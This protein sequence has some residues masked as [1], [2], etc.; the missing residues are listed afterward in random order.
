MNTLMRNMVLMCFSAFVLNTAILAHAD[1]GYSTDYLQDGRNRFSIEEVS[2]S[3]PSDSTLWD[4]SNIEHLG[5]SRKIRISAMSDSTFAV[6][7]NDKQFTFKIFNDSFTNTYDALDRN[8]MTTL[9]INESAAQL[10]QTNTYDSLGRLQNAAMGNNAASVSYG[11]NLRG[12]ATGITSN[13][14][15]QQI[16]YQDT[17]GGSTPCFNG[18][19][20]SMAWMQSGATGNSLKSGRYN[21]TYDMLDRL[22]AAAFADNDNRSFS[23]QYQYDL[24]GNVTNIQRSGVAER[25][26]DGAAETVTYGVIDNVT[27][28][29]SGNRLQ[30]ADDA[31]DALVYD[32]AM[33]FT[34]GANEVEEYAYDAN[35][36]MTMDLNRCIE[37]ITYDW[38]NMPREITFTSGAIT[39][40][41][42]DAAGRKL[43]AEYI[44]PLAASANYATRP[45]PP[46]PPEPPTQP[47]QP[48]RPPSP[49]PAISTV[50]Y[51][52]DCVLRDDS[53]ERVLTP[54]GY[55]ASD[56][57]HYF[58]KD[59]QGNVRCVV[60]HDGAVVESN[61]YY[62]YGGLFAAT[63]S[64]QPYKY[65]SKEL[66]RMHGLDLYDSEAR[67][68]D[69][70]LGRTSTM[71]P[72]AE[73]YYS[74]SPYAWC[75]A[76]PI[77]YID[78]TGKQP[79]FNTK[80]FLIGVTEDSKGLQGM[81]IVMKQSNFHNR[82]T[83]EE[84]S[85][86]NVGIDGLLNKDAK[87]RFNNSYKNLSKRPD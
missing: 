37:S 71:D 47:T 36:N 5:E 14:F 4:F 74:I 86:Y 22:T 63:T 77:A 39:R 64:V 75:A 61:E 23:S 54:N 19:I 85:K 3:V 58:I 27:L 17:T 48:P 76:N 84:A 68:Y 43:R 57:L 8:L 69:S 30:V 50:C 53:L 41:T 80:G 55:I 18:N 59:Y 73:K 52:G 44:T 31:A 34:D 21:Y 42:Y 49:P 11:Y 6:I 38:N 25:I 66:D 87:K 60:R 12:W 13:Q 1:V 24:H 83:T 56:T 20:S 10:L 7:S 67:W 26:T 40:Y 78:K 65:G 33:D 35:G 29:Y 45:T 62:P 79:I 2:V 28:S 9:S 72:L 32:G 51:H 46:R 70:L 81:P 82:M 16:Y 15:S